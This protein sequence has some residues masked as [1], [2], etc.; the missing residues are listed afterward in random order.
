MRP[1]SKG[2]VLLLAAILFCALTASIYLEV[3]RRVDK[4]LK[5]RALYLKCKLIAKVVK[6]IDSSLD[7]S[8]EG[9]AVSRPNDVIEEIARRARSMIMANGVTDV[10]A[11]VYGSWSGDTGQLTVIMVMFTSDGV[12]KA[13]LA[14]SVEL[15]PS[16]SKGFGHA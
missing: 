6:E 9:L 12:I 11:Y 10:D 7:L 8:E 15:T 1:V 3:E 14:K 13:F 5:M 4:L 16:P 2:S